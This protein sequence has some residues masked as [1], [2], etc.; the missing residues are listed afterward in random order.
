MSNTAIKFRAP[1][2]ARSTAQRVA[3]GV[4]ADYIR[5]LASVSTEPT[6]GREPQPARAY[7]CDQS[8]ASRPARVGA[9]AARRHPAR[10]R[11]LLP[12]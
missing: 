9:A 2:V 10:R 8:Q 1:A 5:A 7:D 4:V 12:A 11:A 6:E 3:D